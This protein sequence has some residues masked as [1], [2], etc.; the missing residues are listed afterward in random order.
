MLLTIERIHNSLKTDQTE[1]VTCWLQL[2]E[3]TQ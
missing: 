3:M 2:M 1:I